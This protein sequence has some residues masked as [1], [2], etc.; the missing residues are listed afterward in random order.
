MS[1]CYRTSVSEQRRANRGP[2]AAEPNRRALVAA[3]REVFA[4]VGVEA[5]LSAV[6][7]SAGVGQGTLYR[8]FPD[9]VALAVT[10][11]EDNV[12]ELEALAGD[13]SATL[14]D[15]LALV[16]DQAISSVAFVEMMSPSVADPRLECIVERV[17]GVLSTKLPGA[18]R[19]GTVRD[20]LSAEELFLA[21]EMVSG[22]L[23]KTEGPR[24]R[25][26]ADAAWALLGRGIGPCGS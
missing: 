25:E 26:V 16:T 2:S 9:R 11:F 23:A 8:H 10:V 14:A 19:A 7:R 20:S 22:V 18:I 5:P 1:G 13:P 17:S 3:A 15:V 4:D 12:A 24:R 21:V 6:A